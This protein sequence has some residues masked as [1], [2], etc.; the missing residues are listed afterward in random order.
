VIIP[1]DSLQINNKSVSQ[2]IYGAVVACQNPSLTY[3]ALAAMPADFAVNE[4]KKRNL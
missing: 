1:G 3:M 2:N 4:M